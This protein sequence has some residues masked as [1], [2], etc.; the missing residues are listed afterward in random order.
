MDSDKA[1]D[2]PESPVTKPVVERFQ[3][4]AFTLIVFALLASAVALV[5]LAGK[6]GAVTLKAIEEVAATMCVGA[7]GCASGIIVFWHLLA[8]EN[9]WWGNAEKALTSI[10]LGTVFG[11]FLSG[12]QLLKA[13]ATFLP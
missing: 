3:A 13:V 4:R 5:W 1:S 6:P 7:V 2:Q 10:M 8:H 12:L 11:T 9:E